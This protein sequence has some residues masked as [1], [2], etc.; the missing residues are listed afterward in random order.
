[1]CKT[2]I[3]CIDSLTRPDTPCAGYV[4]VALQDEAAGQQPGLLHHD[5]VDASSGE[6]EVT[7]AIKSTYLV[8]FPVMQ[9]L[10]VIWTQYTG[11]IT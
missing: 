6:Y 2:E 5:E 7:T 9:H 11:K 8:H 1:M 3:G 10:S 4:S